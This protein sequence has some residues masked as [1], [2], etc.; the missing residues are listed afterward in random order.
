[1]LLGPYFELLKIYCSLLSGDEIEADALVKF[2][3][4]CSHLGL[5]KWEQT[6]SENLYSQPLKLDANFNE[7]NLSL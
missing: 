1:M 7:G 2:L 3:L 4:E 6:D 5:L